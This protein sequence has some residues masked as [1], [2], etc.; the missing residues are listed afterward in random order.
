[1]R[2]KPNE[3][4]SKLT[5]NQLDQKRNKDVVLSLLNVYVNIFQVIRATSNQCRNEVNWCLI[6]GAHIRMTHFDTIYS[7]QNTV[8]YQF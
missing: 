6:E 4:D 5:L 7:I 3:T 8:L 1:M 2:A